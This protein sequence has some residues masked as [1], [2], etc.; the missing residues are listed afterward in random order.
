M[1]V[2]EISIPTSDRLVDVLDDRLQAVA[3]RAFGLGTNCVLEL[4]EALLPRPL[5]IPFKVVPQKVE[6][7]L[8]FIRYRVL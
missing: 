6:S 3:L 1:A 8:Y 2:L 5:H 7:P 4:L